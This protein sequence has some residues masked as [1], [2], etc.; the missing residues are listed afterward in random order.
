LIETIGFAVAAR[1]ARERLDA[2]R[3]A[4]E[5]MHLVPVE[6]VVDQPIFTRDQFEPIG[7]NEGSSRTYT[8]AEP[9]QPC[10]WWGTCKHMQLALH[11]LLAC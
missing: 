4:E 3:L 5:V 8:R 11:A 6:R 7:A 10:T 1:S 9:R 2:A